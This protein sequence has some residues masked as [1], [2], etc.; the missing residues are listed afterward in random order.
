M[1]DKTFNINFKATADVSDMRKQFDGL[2][3]T[4]EKLTIPENLKKGLH[5]TF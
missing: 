2:R 5:S 1:A 3:N 4:F